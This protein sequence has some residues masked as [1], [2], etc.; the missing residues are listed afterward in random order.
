MALPYEVHLA[1]RDLA[2]Y[3]WLTATMILGLA[4]AILVMVYIPSTMA[5]FYDDMIDRIVEQNSPHITVWPVER[6]RGELAGA[7]RRQ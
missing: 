4:M 3:P 7:L 5:S 1:R 6:R 2:R